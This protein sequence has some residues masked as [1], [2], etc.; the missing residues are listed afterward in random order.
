MVCLFVRC[1]GFVDCLRLGC[2]GYLLL[3]VGD[4]WWFGY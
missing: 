4:V 2:L 1:V 3:F